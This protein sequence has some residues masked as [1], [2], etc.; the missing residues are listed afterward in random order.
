MN[1]KMKKL[2]LAFAIAG[3][4]F[5]ATSCNEGSTKEMANNNGG[6]STEAAPQEP[7][8]VI[9][10]VVSPSEFKELMNAEGAQLIDVRTPGEVAGG[11]IEG[12]QN[13][14]YNGANF[15][16][17]IDALDRDQPVLVYC[18]SGGRSGRAAAM[19]KE[20]GFKEVYDLQGGYMNWQK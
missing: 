11:M 1:R 20:M 12:A 16:D 14:D 4:S 17:Q 5:G 8:E 10:K 18:R 7:T 3:I 9:N 6:E 13:I 15:K 19:M 2:L